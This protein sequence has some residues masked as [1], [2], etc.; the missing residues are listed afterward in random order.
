MYTA[1]MPWL[2]G[3]YLELVMEHALA[4]WLGWKLPL[5]ITLWRPDKENR[6]PQDGGGLGLVRLFLA[7][8][9]DALE[10]RGTWSKWHPWSGDG[11]HRLISNGN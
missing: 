3:R 10:L 6:G 8:D 7:L 5:L 4:D 1:E 11:R 2:K 9:D